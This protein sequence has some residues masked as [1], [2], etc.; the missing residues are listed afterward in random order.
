MVIEVQDRLKRIRYEMSRLLDYV[1][2]QKYCVNVT[3]R[4]QTVD[5]KSKSMANNNI[6]NDIGEKEKKDKTVI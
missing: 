1:V 4:Y 3:K 6:V 5:L 2:P